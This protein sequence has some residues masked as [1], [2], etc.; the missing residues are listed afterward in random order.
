[1][2]TVLIHKPKS[3]QGAQRGLLCKQKERNQ[4]LIIKFTSNR[5]AIESTRDAN[6][7]NTGKEKTKQ[8]LYKI[9]AITTELL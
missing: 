5:E 3:Q 8:T 1:M 4:I 9:I 6:Q 7:E 2:K